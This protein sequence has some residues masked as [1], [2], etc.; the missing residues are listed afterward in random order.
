MFDRARSTWLPANEPFSGPA[1]EFNKID[2]IIIHYIG[3]D[4]APTNSGNWMLNEH[5]RTMRLDSPYSFMYNGHVGVDGMTWEG[6]GTQ[7]RNAANGSATNRSTWSIVFAVNGQSGASVAQIEGARRLV[8]GIRQAVGRAIPV[9]GHR[10]IGSTQCP[11]TGIYEQ[12]QK[13]LFDGSIQ[14]SRIAGENR[15]GT[16]AAV[17][18]IKFP[19]GAE[20]AF[21]VTGT[22]YPDAL[23]VGPL[24]GTDG[25]ILLTQRDRLPQETADELR[26]LK[27]KRVV[28]VGGLA[29][30][31]AQVE[32][33]ISTLV[34]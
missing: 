18:K 10:D 26:R 5:R 13:G 23:T 30:V 19:A 4:R 20:V 16:A 25:P 34:V 7:F 8:S 24:A 29:A 1:I 32:K 15:Y 6:R 11:G 31:S 3:T 17:S 22:D 27:V 21:V 9:I 12:V 28:I 33:D 14:V 2:S